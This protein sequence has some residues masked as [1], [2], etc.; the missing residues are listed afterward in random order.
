MD[1]QERR[2]QSRYN[3]A[4]P[5]RLAV[6]G[7]SGPGEPP[8]VDCKILN[9]NDRGA[10]LA[11]SVSGAVHHAL[12]GRSRFCRVIT[13]KEAPISVTL[14]GKAVWLD[15]RDKSET[16]EL[17]VGLMFEKCHPKEMQKLSTFLETVINQEAKPTKDA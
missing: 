6:L 16:A 1:N 13:A 4:I 12:L 7:I 8:E 9:L 2:G 14:F 10:L 17:R 11:L 5:A 3:V 15:A